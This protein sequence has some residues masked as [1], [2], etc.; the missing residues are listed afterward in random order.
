MRQFNFANKKK[1]KKEFLFVFLTILLGI[2]IYSFL[3]FKN[4]SGKGKILIASAKELKSALAENDIDLLNKK[5]QDFTAKYLD[6]KKSAQS[7]YSA[8][9]IPY[10]ADFKNSVEAGEYLL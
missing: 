4:L 8:S 3:T 7:V 1:S 5:M 6:F 10:V 2:F 9:F